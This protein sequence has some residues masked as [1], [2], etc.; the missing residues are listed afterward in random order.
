[1]FNLEEDSE[2]CLPLFCL[3]GCILPCGFT[4]TYKSFYII[5]AKMSILRLNPNPHRISRAYVFPTKIYTA[6]LLRH[7]P[8]STKSEIV[9]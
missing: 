9:P 4:I 2:T 8:Q 7:K 5:P 3:S 6:L 1:M